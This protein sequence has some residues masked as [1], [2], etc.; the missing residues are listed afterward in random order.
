MP[1]SPA[2]P[3]ALL[4]PLAWV[5]RRTLAFATGVD[6]RHDV[7]AVFF[8]LAPRAAGMDGRGIDV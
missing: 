4:S 7:A 5:G 2:I 8:T 6:A 3:P 1:H